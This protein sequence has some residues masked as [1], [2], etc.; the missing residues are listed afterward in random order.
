MTVV[1]TN[2]GWGQLGGALVGLIVVLCYK[3]DILKGPSTG[4]PAIDYCWHLLIGLGCI[5]GTIALY[6]HLTIPKTPC[7]T[8]DIE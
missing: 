3:T 1:F 4:A 7:F 8:M 6:F 2:Q 5:P